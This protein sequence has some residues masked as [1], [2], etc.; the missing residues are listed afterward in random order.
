MAGHITELCWEFWALNGSQ[1]YDDFE[2]D[3]FDV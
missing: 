2:N 1:G 3:D